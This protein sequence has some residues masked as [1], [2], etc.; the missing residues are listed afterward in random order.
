MRKRIWLDEVAEL[1]LGGER[2]DSVCARLGVQGDSVTR[3]ILRAGRRGEDVSVVEKLVRA[4]RRRAMYDAI[5]RRWQGK[6]RTGL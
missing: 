1:L 3:A 5:A 6:R 4:E 2:L